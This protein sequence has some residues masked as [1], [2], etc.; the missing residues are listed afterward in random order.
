[1][2]VSYFSASSWNCRCADPAETGDL[3]W[4]TMSNSAKV[5]A[6][7]KWVNRVPV[8]DMRP[9]HEGRTEER[10]DFARRVDEACRGWGFFQIVNHRV[11]AA[12]IE[13][14]LAEMRRFFALPREAKRAVRRSEDNPWGYYDSELTKNVRDW[15]EIF[16]FRR[17]SKPELP[18]HHPA[19]RSEEGANR[20]PAKLPGFREVMLEYSRPSGPTEC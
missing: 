19:N 9:W 7:E 5:D 14:C 2:H 6:E 13:A 10:A 18:D 12:L 1:M 20:W 15:K 11:P 16:D 17:L 8:L 3:T 4:R